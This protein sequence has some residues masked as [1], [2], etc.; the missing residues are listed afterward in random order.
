LACY[1]NE[2]GKLQRVLTLKLKR[3]KNCSFS[4][5]EIRMER[6]KINV[7]KYGE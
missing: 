6:K 2:A 4:F 1:F 3:A 7:W 5:D